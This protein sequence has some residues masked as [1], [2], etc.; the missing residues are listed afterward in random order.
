MRIVFYGTPQFAVASLRKILENNYNIVAVV[1]SPDKPA[2]R[3]MKLNYSAVKQYAI[4]KNLKILQPENLKSEAFYN[5]LISLKPDLQIVI[6]FRMLPEKIWKFPPLGTFNLHASLLPDYRGAAPINRAIMNG[7][8]VTGVTTFFL[9]HEIDTGNII[10][11]ESIV[12]EPSDNAGTLHDK[13]METGAELVLKTLEKIKNGVAIEIPQ[14]HN[15]TYHLAP[16]I[17]SADCKIDW[18]RNL[19]EINN[20]IRGLSPYPGAFTSINNKLLKIFNGYYVKE[21]VEKTGIFEITNEKKL[22]IS[23]SD[24]WYYP[25]TVQ[26]EGKRKMEI[27]EFINGFKI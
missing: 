20:Q 24:G 1:T 18:K 23:C 15:Q 6:A 26:Y 11:Q 8:R 3:G 2:G 10:L 9:K 22:R 14:I 12:I 25:Q 16:K 4:E 21:K 19:N 17:F 7:E 5:E 13:L 27:G